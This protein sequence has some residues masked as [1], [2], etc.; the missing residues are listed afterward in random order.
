M[1]GARYFFADGQGPTHGLHLPSYRPLYSW[2]FT[3]SLVM[4]SQ[5][6]TNKFPFLK[7]SIDNAKVTTILPARYLNNVQILDDP[8]KQLRWLSLST[9]KTWED[10]SQ[11]SSFS[12]PALKL[13]WLSKPTDIL[14][15]PTATVMNMHLP[16]A[17]RITPCAPFVHF[18]ILIWPSNVKTPLAARSNTRSPSPGAA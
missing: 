9:L 10:S 6:K 7:Q 4:S 16:D 13:K 18:I 1:S 15:A 8:R 17:L 12:Q 14:N 11:A 2:Q 5:T 3:Q